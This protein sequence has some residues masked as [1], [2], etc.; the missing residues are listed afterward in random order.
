MA[1]QIVNFAVSASLAGLTVAGAISA[2]VLLAA[3]VLLSLSNA[4]E[5]PTRQAVVPNLVPT[6][7]LP[8]A[9]ALN[10]SQRSVSS[11]VGPSL[12]RL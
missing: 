4:L 1:V 2:Q 8:A 12:Q 11:I 9:I 7:H 6:E 10:T 3:A 5:M